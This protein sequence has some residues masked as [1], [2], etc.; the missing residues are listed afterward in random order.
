[1]SDSQTAD[2]IRPFNYKS[3]LRDSMSWKTPSSANLSKIWSMTG[4]N[5]E[6]EFLTA[7]EC[8]T[9]LTFLSDLPTHLTYLTYL[10][11]LPT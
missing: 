11:D 2:L 8:T 7:T 1:M 5:S 4:A 6:S 3:F 10:P 9:Y